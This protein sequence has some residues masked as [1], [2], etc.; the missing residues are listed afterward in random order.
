MVGLARVGDREQHALRG[1]VG[2]VRV[3][4]GAAE[5]AHVFVAAGGRGTVAARV[6]DVELAASRVVGRER[7][8]EQP[9]LGAVRLLDLARD[10]EEGCRLLHAAD[11]QHD[12]AALLGDEQAR[13]IARGR[14]HVRG[15][16]EAAHLHELN[17]VSGRR[18][19]DP[20]QQRSKASGLP[21]H[22]MK[23]A[24]DHKDAVGVLCGRVRSRN[25]ALIRPRRIGRA[26]PRRDDR[27][28]PRA[29][30]RPRAR[31]RRA[32]LAPPEPALH[33]RRAQ[34]AGRRAGSRAAG[35]R[36]RAGRP[37]RHLEPEP[38]RV[39]AGAVRDR[40]DRASSSSTSTPPTGPPSSSTRS[41]SPAAGC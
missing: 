23:V 17:R 34:R 8:R 4:G 3:R 27:G 6:I 39:G 38:R 19:H 35:A 1:G 29:H 2:D 37:A 22:R 13:G 9:L 14:G 20:H 7:H 25:A 33:L 24:T 30:R 15:R 5:L 11:H 26:A 28:E 12:L 10:V 41:T 16:R 18:G 32:R 31:R 21:E 36:L 40:Q